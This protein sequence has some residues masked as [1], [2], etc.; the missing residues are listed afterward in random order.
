MR[1]PP[2]SAPPPSARPSWLDPGRVIHRNR[3]SLLAA[4]LGLAG[5]GAWGG[6]RIWR[7]RQPAA[8]PIPLAPQP[9]GSPLVARGMLQLNNGAL[10]SGGWSG[11]NIDD[12]LQLTAISDLGYWLQAR[13]QLAEDGTPIGLDA[14]RH[15]PLDDGFLDSPPGRLTTDAESLAR[16]ADGSWLIGFERWQHITRHARIDAPGEPWPGPA[17]LHQAPLNA[18]LESL[19]AL[20]DGRCLALSEGLWTGPHGWP[21][22]WLGGP[23]NWMPLGYRPGEGFAASDACGLP[24]GS[25]LVVERS[26]NFRQGFRGRLMRIPAA[27]IAAARPE[28]LLQGEL[29]A[30][31]LPHENWE[32][33]TSFRHQD[34]TW[35]AMLTDDN[36][37][38]FQ[39][40]LL[41]F[42][43]LRDS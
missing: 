23:G 12:R 13:L 33:V 25:A 43:V 9:P 27:A 34:A 28:T 1:P 21:R 30:E 11:L 20:P 2:F 41:A 26:F 36:E 24:D 35:I 16:L 6:R 10:G 31:Q 8:R 19:A 4:G 37:M 14:V 40:G 39:E 29:L 15:G 22:A 42:F 38:F 3:R 32:G 18:G 17:E 7:G 5:L